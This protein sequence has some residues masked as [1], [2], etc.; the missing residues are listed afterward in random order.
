[1]PLGSVIGNV[2]LSYVG[3]SNVA[4]NE[5]K[6]EPNTTVAITMCESF[7]FHSN[8]DRKNLMAWNNRMSK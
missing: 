6:T 7:C 1:V 8:K 5:L 2:V 4:A 3:I